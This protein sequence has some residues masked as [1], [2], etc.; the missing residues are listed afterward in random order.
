MTT[1]VKSSATSRKS[2]AKVSAKEL[3][4]VVNSVSAP[5]PAGV[6]LSDGVTSVSSSSAPVA[7][8]SSSASTARAKN[9]DL[10]S[11]LEN[12]IYFE[13]FTNKLGVR[14][15]SAKI[16]PFFS[17]PEWSGSAADMV[18]TSLSGMLEAGVINQDQFDTMWRAAAKNAGIDLSAPLVSVGRVLAVIRREGLVREFVSLVGMSFSAVRDHI[19]NNGINNYSWRLSCGAV[20]ANSDINNYVRCE[21]CDVITASSILSALFSLSVVSDFKKRL[22]SAK[23]VARTQLHN[24]LCAAIR[25]ASQLGLSDNDI[26]T[27][28][29]ELTCYVSDIDYQTRKRLQN[30]YVAAVNKINTYNDEILMLGGAPLVDVVGTPAKVIKKIKRALYL[31]GLAYSDAHTC[32][33]LLNQENV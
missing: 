12:A 23:S 16:V 6:G 1:R 25:A 21:K 32:A 30:N 15:L 27:E 28:I 10:R 3:Q 5:A 33:V 22:S 19:R 4:T 17:A 18:K 8:G 31:R 29:R 13:K 24:S 14:E 20:L 26:Q 11:K 9:M 2:S 7:V